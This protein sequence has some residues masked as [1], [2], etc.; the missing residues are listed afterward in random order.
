MCRFLSASPFISP[1]LVA[2]LPVLPLVLPI[3]IIGKPLRSIPSLVLLPPSSFPSV[4]VPISKLKRGLRARVP[5]SRFTQEEDGHCQVFSACHFFFFFDQ[6]NF[7]N[8]I[9]CPNA[10]SFWGSN[11]R[12]CPH[13]RKENKSFLTTP[14]L[15]SPFS[16][17]CKILR[18]DEDS[19]FRL[20]SS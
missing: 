12:M 10:V 20:P 1:Q 6:F 18:S 3:N 13:N 5:V 17:I 2:F 7:P 16:R 8:S 4:R 9:P 14:T 19:F 11:F 15:C